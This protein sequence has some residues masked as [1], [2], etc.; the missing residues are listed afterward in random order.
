MNMDQLCVLAVWFINALL[1]ITVLFV[2]V[3]LNKTIKDKKEF[4]EI[5]FNFNFEPKETDFQLVDTLI[6]ENFAKYRILK[7]ESVDKLYINETI[8]NEIFEY[9]LTETLHQLSPIHLQKLSYIYN[10][11]KLNDIIAQKINIAILDY[12]VEVNSSIRTQ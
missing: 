1:L 7:L 11:D 5:K 12:T 8:Q 10:M 9:V 2:L 3:K 4:D 6:Q